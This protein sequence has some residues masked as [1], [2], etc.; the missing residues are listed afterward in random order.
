MLGELTQGFQK[1]FLGEYV[2][3]FLFLLNVFVT[4]DPKLE[5]NISKIIFQCQVL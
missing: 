3:K 2:F 4:T 5:Q 1:L